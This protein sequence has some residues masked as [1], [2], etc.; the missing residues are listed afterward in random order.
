VERQAERN[1]ERTW[2]RAP[3]AGRVRRTH[4]DVGQYLAPGT[5]VAEIFAT[6]YIE[7]RLPVRDSELAFLDVPLDGSSGRDGPTVVLRGEFAGTAH[8]WEGSIV[9]TEGEI[10][11]QTRMVHLIA[12]VEAPYEGHGSAP[13]SVGLFVG[14]EIS[15]EPLENV[16]VIPRSALR[17][18]NE[19]LLVDSEDRLRLRAVDVARIERERVF[20]RG[21]VEPGERI[22]LS[23][24]QVV[25]DGMKVRTSTDAPKE[26]SEWTGGEVEIDP[27]AAG[28]GAPQVLLLPGGEA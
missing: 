20:L 24:L 6:D 3:Y 2:I 14:A 19:V 27:V 18:G 17:Q 26:T 1:L 9:R 11:P 21:G 10:D 16:F 12:R 5:P 15:G 22:C 4:V 8:S 25:S 23:S 13:L 28:Q 7:V